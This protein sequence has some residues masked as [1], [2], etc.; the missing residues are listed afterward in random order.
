M[1][2]YAPGEGSSVRTAVNNKCFM[3]EIRSVTLKTRLGYSPQCSHGLLSQM[4]PDPSV[5][6]T[7]H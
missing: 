7:G 1:A 2:T 5:G 6:T 3:E 4:S